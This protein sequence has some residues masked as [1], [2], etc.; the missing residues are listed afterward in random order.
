MDNNLAYRFPNAVT[1]KQAVKDSSQSFPDE[2][3]SHYGKNDNNESKL[4]D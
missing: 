2:V 3:I 1:V 4:R